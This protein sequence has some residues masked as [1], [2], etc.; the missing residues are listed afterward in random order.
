M[1]YATIDPPPPPTPPPLPRYVTLTLS[2]L[3]AQVLADILATVSGSGDVDHEGNRSERWSRR[4]LTDS[5]AVALERVGIVF[6]NV[7]VGDDDLSGFIA[8]D[9]SPR[10]AHPVHK[11]WCYYSTRPPA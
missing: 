6:H 4:A 3:E 7:V 5:I 2:A 10:P 11:R 9:D 1:A 8:F